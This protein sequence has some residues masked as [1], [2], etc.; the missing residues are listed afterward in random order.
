MA[1]EMGAPGPDVEHHHHHHTGQR[2]LDVTLAVSAIFISLMSLLL[3]LQHGRA[4]ER[5]VQMSSW[6]YVE[7]GT[8]TAREDGSHRIVIWVANNG[9]GPARVESIEVFYQGVAQPD[10]NALVRAMLKISDPNRRL[11]MLQSSPLDSVLPARQILPLFDLMLEHFSPEEYDI[12]RHELLRTTQR[13]CYCSV[14]DE[15]AIRDSN[16][17]K[18]EPV[19][20]CPVPKVMF[21]EFVR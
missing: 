14:F 17:S 18:P 20:T 12:L 10:P 7:V 13:V 16:T 6:P 21:R 11:F 15:C 3:A 4:M 2:W 1:A 19:R 5:M 8:S 9:V